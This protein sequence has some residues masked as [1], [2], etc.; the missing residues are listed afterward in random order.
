MSTKS[1]VLFAIAGISLLMA[2]SSPPPAAARLTPRELQTINSASWAYFHGDSQAV[3]EKLSPVVAKANEEKIGLVDKALAEHGA[4]DSE[5]LLLG[6]RMALMQQSIDTRKLPKPGEREAV[7]LL[8]ELREQVES[9]LTQVERSLAMDRAGPHPDDLEGFETLLWSLHVSENRLAAAGRLVDSMKEIARSIPR[10][11]INKL[12]DDDREIVTAD[13]GAL[14]ERVTQTSGARQEREMELR[15][16]RLRVARGIL[17]DPQLTKE[18][19][20]AAFT[21]DLDARL[22]TDFFEQA[23]KQGRSL[24]SDLLKDPR[25]VDRV[26]EDAARARKLAG[27]LTAKSQLFFE[28]LHWWMRGRYGLGPEVGGLAKSRAA[29][30][31]AAAQFALS[32]P[33]TTPKPLDPAWL[34]E[35]EGVPRF[36]RRHHYLWAW[37]DRRLYLT[38]DGLKAQKIADGPTFTITGSRFW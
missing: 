10:G 28:G 22:V 11:Q 21:A 31:S 30:R 24:V 20:L 3:L 1:F 5:R 23:K 34:T 14:G 7:R 15:I 38:S 6:A 4:P 9:V 18:R 35:A 19:F 13:H 27:T 26:A 33:E 36:E 32:M 29:L 12:S 17:E 16:G 37:E 2:P 8:K 25:T